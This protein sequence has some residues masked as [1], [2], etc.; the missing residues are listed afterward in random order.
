M[1]AAP[2][3]ASSSYDVFRYSGGTGALV[4]SV[5]TA[6]PLACDDTGLSP[7]TTYGY[8]VE[9]RLGA[10][11]RSG[12]TPQ[13]SATT[14]G[15]PNF[16]VE[17]VTPGTKTAGTSFDLRL[18]ARTDTPADPTYTGSHALTFSGPGQHPGYAA[19]S[20]P[21]SATFAAGVAVVAVTLRKAEAVTLT[22][23]EGSRTGSTTVT[24][25]A[26]A[27]AG[28]RYTSS[29]HDCSDGTADVVDNRGTWT[30]KVSRVDAWGNAVVGGPIS[31]TVTKPTGAG[32]S[33]PAS[34]LTIG[35][36]ASESST[37]TSYQIASGNPPAVTIT[38][39]SGG[40]TPATC[41]V[42]R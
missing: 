34:P 12:Q 5:P 27:V 8:T 1:P 20:Y 3:P 26:G 24:V 11:W 32:G 10:N 30:T 22:V 2:S 4:C 42:D 16:L 31:V 41:A 36:D 23:S 40:L 15:V 39:A 14:A 6:S 35:L 13:V 25:V 28:L 37:A 29:S 19:P 17:L 33:T 21:T 18:T 9:S 7:S 38:A